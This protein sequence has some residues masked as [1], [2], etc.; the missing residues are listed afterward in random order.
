M[1]RD[2]MITILKS[3]YPC[4]AVENEKLFPFSVLASMV[5][6]IKGEKLSACLEDGAA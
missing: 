6:V 4:L 3:K 1:T 5:E 2:E